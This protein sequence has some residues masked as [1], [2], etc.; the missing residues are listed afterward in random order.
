MKKEILEALKAKFVGV[1]EAILNRIADKLAKT[2]IKQEDVATAIEGVTFQQVLESYGDSRA[3]EAQQTAVTNYEKKHG[4]KDGKKVEEPKPTEQPKPNEETK[5]GKEDMPV[6][7]KALIDSNKTLSDKLSAMEGEKIA[8]S[9]KS[10][11]EAILKN[12]PEKIRQRYEKDFVR[13]T[14][15]DDEDFNSWIGEITPDVEAITNECQAKGGVVTRPKAGAAGG[16][17]EE[18]NPYLEARIKEREAATTTPAIQGL[19]TETTK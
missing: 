17:G 11:L 16:K 14:F 8:T 3:T 13:M 10:S 9:R 1:S 2:V 12:A 6:W 19:A 4:L 7:A 15:K 5:P 18:K